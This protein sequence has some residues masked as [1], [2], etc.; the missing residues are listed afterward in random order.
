[1]KT[2]K[3]L[4]EENKNFGR[5]VGNN[6]SPFRVGFN[7]STI[8]ELKEFL[9]DSFSPEIEKALFTVRERGIIT[10]K[11]QKELE[12]LGFRLCF[13]GFKSHSR[14]IYIYQDRT[15]RWFLSIGVANINHAGRGF[16]IEV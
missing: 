14:D 10:L 1:M 4:K 16:E 9:G 6:F 8:E 12:S 15:N 5:M 11:K 7:K 3:N 2:L 13:R